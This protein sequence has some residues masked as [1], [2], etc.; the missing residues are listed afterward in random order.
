M[1]ETMSDT[2][3]RLDLLE[4]RV[5]ALAKQ[6]EALWDGL[7]YSATEE[8]PLYIWSRTSSPRRIMTYADS[9]RYL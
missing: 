1:A 7:Y 2:I 8:G 5:S 3:T 9:E 6:L 4:K